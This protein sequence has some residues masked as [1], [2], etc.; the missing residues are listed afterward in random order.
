MSQSLSASPAFFGDLSIVSHPAGLRLADMSTIF[1]PSSAMLE[2]P[3]YC[4]IITLSQP[5]EKPLLTTGPRHRRLWRWNGCNASDAPARPRQ[6]S[7]PTGRDTPSVFL[8]LSWSQ[9]SLLIQGDLVL[10]ACNRFDVDT[11]KAEAGYG[12]V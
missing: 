11:D 4:A 6:S 7:I 2:N 9:H 8:L 5:W 1:V 3:P 12:R 10:L